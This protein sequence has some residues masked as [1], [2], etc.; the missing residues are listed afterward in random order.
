MEIKII[1]KDWIEIAIGIQNNWLD[2]KNLTK[3]WDNEIIK[4]PIDDRYPYVY[5]AE[6]NS[7]EDVI[8]LINRFIVEDYSINIFSEESMKIDYTLE[9]V[10][11]SMKVWEYYFLNPIYLSTD[12]ITKKLEEDIYNLWCDFV[13]FNVDWTNFLWITGSRFN[14][15]EN[16]L[17]EEFIKYVKYLEKELYFL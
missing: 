10:K 15:S 9:E 7:K 3:F 2:Y 14:K 8:K 17:Y 16:E 6:Q 4:I 12:S 13:Y 1:L 11:K 5:W